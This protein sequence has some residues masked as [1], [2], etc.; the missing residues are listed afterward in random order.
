M[1]TILVADDDA[2]I[3]ELVCLFLRKDGFTTVEAADGKEAMAVYASTHVDIY[4]IGLCEQ[5]SKRGD[6]I[7]RNR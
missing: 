4:G 6:C 1:P 3:R 5:I 2:N 7:C